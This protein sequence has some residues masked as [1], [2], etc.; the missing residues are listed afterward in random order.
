MRELLAQHDMELQ[1]E[2]QQW[3]TIRRWLH[4]D[5][6]LQSPADLGADVYRQ[7]EAFEAIVFEAAKQVG[8]PANPQRCSSAADLDAISRCRR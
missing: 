3:T 7:L 5:G 8:D 1:G 2:G 4:R 6:R